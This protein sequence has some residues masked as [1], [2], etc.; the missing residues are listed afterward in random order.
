M[1][2]LERRERV[3]IKGGKGEKERNY[4]EDGRRWRS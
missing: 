2:E 1:E 3:E 4:V